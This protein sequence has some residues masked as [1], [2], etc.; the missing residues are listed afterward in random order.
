MR[1]QVMPYGIEWEEHSDTTGSRT[2]KPPRRATYL[3]ACCGVVGLVAGFGAG[4]AAEPAARVGPTP[5]AATAAA[6]SPEAPV[7][8]IVPR[9]VDDLPTTP[10]AAERWIE[11][12]ASVSG[13]GSSPDSFLPGNLPALKH[14][15]ERYV[16][17]LGARAQQPF[18]P[19]DLPRTP[20]AIEQWLEP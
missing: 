8:G 16:E 20:D 7:V 19:A 15:A 1:K 6:N 4:R 5:A 12:T 2:P 14:D 9:T 11:N 13:G 18:C 17:W 3:A 10:D